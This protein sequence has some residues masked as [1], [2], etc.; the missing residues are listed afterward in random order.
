MIDED[1]LTGETEEESNAVPS[2]PDAGWRTADGFIAYDNYR[3]A[4]DYE[5]GKPRV[6]I[7]IDNQ[8]SAVPYP[9]NKHYYV[10]VPDWEFY[11]LAP[12]SIELF[13]LKRTGDGSY[14]KYLEV[15]I[16]RFKN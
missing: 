3:H 2:N 7:I 14:E 12:L 5:D 8:D 6:I 1:E 9:N 13:E 16:F 15:L 4:Y 10:V 11:R